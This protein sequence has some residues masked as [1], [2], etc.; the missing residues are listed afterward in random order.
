MST[1]CRCCCAAICVVAVIV[2]SDKDVGPDLA[3]LRCILR[4]YGRRW[5][6]GRVKPKINISST[7]DI[8]CLQYMSMAVG[9]LRTPGSMQDVYFMD[10]TNEHII[11]HGKMSVTYTP[12]AKNMKTIKTITIN[13]PQNKIKSHCNDYYT[14]KM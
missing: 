7:F 5:G 9:A 3:E 2:R 13:L 14:P 1:L 8:N 6:T 12:T 4:I 11:P 10:P